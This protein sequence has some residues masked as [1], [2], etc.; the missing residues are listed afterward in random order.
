MVR[1]VHAVPVLLALAAATAACRTRPSDCRHEAVEQCLWER[2]VAPPTPDA[3]DDDDGDGELDDGDGEV[4]PETTKLDDTLTAMTEIIAAGLEWALVDERARSLCS[5]PPTVPEPDPALPPPNPDAWTCAIAGL[6]LGEQPLEL[7]ASEGVLSLSAIN[8][9]DAESTTLFELA[10]A[11]FG[12]WC[13][14]RGFREVESDGL[15]EFYRCSLADGPYLVVARFPRDLEAGRWQ[16]SIAI[17]D[18]G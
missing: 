6:E 9:G 11:R 18:A 8:L 17:V 16:I 12:G 4:T 10:Q 15:S 13:A 5:G 1:A 7:E 2:G 3:N 14:N